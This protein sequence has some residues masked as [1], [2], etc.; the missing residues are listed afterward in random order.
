M[1]RLIAGVVIVVATASASDGND[2]PVRRT[3]LDNGLVVITKEDHRA[4]VVSVQVW[5]RTGSIH[6]GDRLGAGLSHIL[7]HMLFKGTPSRPVSQFARDVEAI[8]GSTNAYT[9]YDRTVYYIDAPADGNRPGT[10]H[11]TMTAL[12]ILADSIQN[13][14]LDATEYER[15][16]EVVRREQAMGNDDPNR[17]LFKL[18][19]STAYTQHPFRH[20][21][22]GYRE[23]YDRFG[24]EAALDYYRKRYA[25]NNMHVVVVGAIDATKVEAKVRDLFKD[26][27]RAAIAPV[28]LPPEPAQTG[29]RRRDEEMPTLTLSRVQIGFHTVNVRHPDAPALDVLA[30][31]AG[32]GR[33]SR[34]YR[35]LR[36]KL[37]LVHSIGAYS[38]TP[39]EPGLFAI[40]L[41]CDADKRADAE[42]AS[43]A[44]L[45]KFSNPL[46]TTDELRK[47]IQKSVADNLASRKTMSGQASDFGNSELI[48]DDPLFSDHYL[49]ALKRVTREDVRRVARAYLRDENRTIVSLNPPNTL[50]KAEIATAK[51]VD[52]E[53]QKIEF[54]NGMK[55]LIREDHRLP[56]V[57]LVTVCKGGLLA[58]TEE[59]NGVTALMASTLVKGTKSRSAEQIADAIESVGGSLSASGGQ[60]SFSISAEVLGENFDLGFDLWSDVILNPTFPADA[61]ER[62]R[63]S[64]LASIRQ[65]QEAIMTVAGQTLR[66][67]IFG[68]HPYRF[69]AIG[70]EASVKKLTREHVAKFHQTYCA[71][72][73]MVIAIF[74]DVNAAR[75]R[76]AVEK[77]FGGWQSRAPELPKHSQTPLSKVDRRSKDLPKEQAV[78]LVGFNGI[79]LFS[80]DR[81]ALA[82][83]TEVM[84]GMGSRL[85]VRLRDELGLCYYTGAQQT[86]GLDAGVYYFYVGTVPQ[87]IE[88]CEAEIQKQIARLR[89][90]P[91]SDDELARAK[92]AQIGGY[93]M[94]LQS[95]GGLASGCALDELYGLGFKFY[96]SLPDRVVRVTADQIQAAA[97]KYFRTDAYAVI[98]VRREPKKE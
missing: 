27:K 72:N 3:V 31:V 44:E 12:E 62:E 70:T 90:E 2:A 75:V 82:V 52:P 34:L 80:P 92:S 55:L 97:R 14:T 38:N 67:S 33:S 15:E 48:V 96:Q 47:A 42:T 24:R 68:T 79:N 65:Q 53:I 57:N 59:S 66:Q 29:P 10:N 20:P 17:R 26:Y 81:D 23:V 50:K 7:E 86:V 8:G 1:K 88:L 74:G 83:L 94:S 28:F 18:L 84:G 71:P 16:M 36:E 51:H 56:F 9:N 58:E 93:K 54:P 69:D 46:I 63:V 43:L 77:K 89:D 6:E 61:L 85:F 35:E 11:G 73:N 45:R 22:I 78:L 98:V 21:V 25:P 39:A 64:Q 49:E 30:I 41:S 87:K 37:K 5:V 76:A 4:P 13:S 40:S 95:N 19:Y 91:V 60:S 32:D